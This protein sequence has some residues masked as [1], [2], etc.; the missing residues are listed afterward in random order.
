MQLSF[1]RVESYLRCP[2]KYYLHYILGYDAVI[3]YDDAANPLLIGS[4]MHAGI[5]AGDAQVAV[6][7]YNKSYPVATDRTEEECMKFLALV[8][9]AVSLLQRNTSA[10]SYTYE[11]KIDHE[12]FVGFIDLLIE[13]NDGTYG[14]FDFKYSNNVEHYVDSAQVHLYKYFYET[15]T[16]HEVTRL[17]YIFIPKVSI[18]QKKSESLGEFRNRLRDTLSLVDVKVVHVDYDP[19]KVIGHM[20]NVKKVLEA[21]SFPKAEGPLCRWC[22]F[23]PYCQQS[24]IWCL[25]KK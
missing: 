10:K 2:Y 1:S 21:K 7:T 11:Y 15:L 18:R 20:L 23:A 16:G 25:N 4:A 9:K 13:R 22:D 14:I 8:P 24:A 17:G 19:T 3:N 6:D 12:D 5:E